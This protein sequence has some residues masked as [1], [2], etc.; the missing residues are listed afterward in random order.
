MR[1]LVALARW[2]LIILFTGFAAII[3]AKLLAGGIRMTGLL[4]GTAGFSPGRAQLLVFTVFVAMDYLIRVIHSPSATALPSISPAIVGVLG[5]SQA[6]YLGGK[7]WSL[8]R[9]NQQ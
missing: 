2:E 4:Q 1:G 8:L 3:L 6:V 7:A 9:R 5:G